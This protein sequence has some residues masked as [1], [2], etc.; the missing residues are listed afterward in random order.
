MKY[1]QYDT[2]R[3]FLFGMRFFFGLWLLY[4]GLVKWLQIKPENFVGFITGEFDKT[5]SPHI[6]NVILAWLILVAEPFLAF[7]ILTGRKARTAWTLTAMFM[8]MLT[9]G[10]TILMKPEVTTTWQ[11]LLLALFCAAFSDPEPQT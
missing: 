10:H 2:R 8:F 11:F 1:C 6:L 4:A 3:F 5:W 9:M 7:F